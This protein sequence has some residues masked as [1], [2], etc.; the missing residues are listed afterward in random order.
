MMIMTA[1]SAPPRP[2]QTREQDKQGQMMNGWVH[3][4]SWSQLA[5]VSTLCF[6]P[7][8]PTEELLL[9]IGA[10]EMFSMVRITISVGAWRLEFT[11]FSSSLK[12]LK[13]PVLLTV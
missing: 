2:P 11:C 7:G 8:L 12:A 4:I 9:L 1:D 6:H 5:D 3:F 13:K 10:A